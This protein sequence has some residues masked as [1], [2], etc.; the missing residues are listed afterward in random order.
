[1][2]CHFLVIYSREH[3][4]PL[5]FDIK[6]RYGLKLKE[7]FGMLTGSSLETKCP[8]VKHDIMIRKKE[9]RSQTKLG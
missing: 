9:G 7:T 2:S 4:N 5:C 6:R 3:F 1:M 8:S